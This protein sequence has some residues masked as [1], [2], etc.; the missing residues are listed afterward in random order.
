MVNLE[1]VL[2]EQYPLADRA[3]DLFPVNVD[4]ISEMVTEHLFGW[5]SMMLQGVIYSLSDIGL[6]AS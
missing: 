3:P 6:K 4:H 1:S 2:V 5:I